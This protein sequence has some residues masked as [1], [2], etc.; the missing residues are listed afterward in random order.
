MI[1]WREEME[2]G[3]TSIDDDHKKLFEIINQFDTCKNRKAAELTSKRL[4]S[5][6]STHFAREEEIQ[7]EYRYPLRYEQKQ[8]HERILKELRQLIRT[9]FIDNAQS[10]EQVIAGLSDLMRKWIMDHVMHSDMKMK[11]FFKTNTTP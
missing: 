8:E 5:Y 1:Q 2:I 6:T 3:V 10:D 11:P 9:A 4:F 7:S